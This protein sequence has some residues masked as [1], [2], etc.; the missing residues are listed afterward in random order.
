MT[1]RPDIY[2]KLAKLKDQYHLEKGLEG[3]LYPPV[4]EETFFQ[5]F[6]K[7]IKH[8][9]TDFYRKILI[10]LNLLNLKI[11]PF[12][13][14]KIIQARKKQIMKQFKIYST[15]QIDT[16]ERKQLRQRIT[17]KLYADGADN[18]GR[19]CFI[20]MGLPGSGKSS[21]IEKQL[22]EEY[23]AMKVDYD[24]VKPHIPEYEDGI[25]NYIV[26]DEAKY[27][28][29]RILD[30]VVEQGDSVVVSDPG[31]DID[32]ILS[33]IKNFKENNFKIHLRFVYVSPEKAAQRTIKRFNEDGRFTDPVI[34]FSFGNKP[35]ENY[36]TLISSYNIYFE[37]FEA[38]SN[39]SPESEPPCKLVSLPEPTSLLDV[40]TE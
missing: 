20:V 14:K 32:D 35:L 16:P 4:L 34:H 27:I 8:L 28:K 26:Y 24:E 25:G 12:D 29:N 6:K 22:L 7:K 38:Y 11:T 33:M 3:K 15:L 21:T 2:K 39:E 37:S 17:H 5:K 13:N 40:M 30:I 9:M 10:R 1:G 36:K 31:L 19:N 23:Q 18:K